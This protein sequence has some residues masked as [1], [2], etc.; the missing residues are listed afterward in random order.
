M[1]YW[2]EKSTSIKWHLV[3]VVDQD[4]CVDG[5]L[6]LQVFPEKDNHNLKF[7]SLFFVT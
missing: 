3:E 6:S 7:L 4:A 1:Y 2:K 5:F